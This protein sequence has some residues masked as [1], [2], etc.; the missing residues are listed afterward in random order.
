MICMQYPVRLKFIIYDYS[1]LLI[2]SKNQLICQKKDEKGP[3]SW[4]LVVIWTIYLYQY[5]FIGQ[6]SNIKISL[7]FFCLFVIVSVFIAFYINLFISK[8]NKYKYLKIYSGL[9]IYGILVNKYANTQSIL[10]QNLK[11][12]LFLILYLSLCLLLGQVREV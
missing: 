7:D 9:E 10:F 8:P 6:N 1:F 2:I 3:Q 12:I 4:I 11:F 5:I